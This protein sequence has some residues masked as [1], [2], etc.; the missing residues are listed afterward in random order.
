MISQCILRVGKWICQFLIRNLIRIVQYIYKNFIVVLCLRIR[1][2]LVLLICGRGKLAL[3][4][5]TII[6]TRIN[7]QEIRT[8]FGNDEN[9]K[10]RFIINEAINSIAKVERKGFQA[11][12]E[13]SCLNIYIDGAYYKFESGKGER[14]IVV[15]YENEIPVTHYQ[16]FPEMD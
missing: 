9:L 8:C 2:L 12:L 7:E 13:N 14:L 10:L 1:R 15:N 3:P 5:S 4:I 6:C 11:L 16:G